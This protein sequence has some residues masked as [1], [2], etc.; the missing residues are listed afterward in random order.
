M[1]SLSIHCFEVSINKMYRSKSKVE[2]VEEIE[3]VYQQQIFTNNI[4]QQFLKKHDEIQQL[5][6]TFMRMKT[7]FLNLDTNIS[8]EKSNT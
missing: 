6:Q 5:R 1:Y 4:K 7:P 8:L 2:N 3:L